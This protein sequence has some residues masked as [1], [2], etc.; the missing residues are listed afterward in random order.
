MWAHMDV[1][2]MVPQGWKGEFDGWRP[3]DAWSNAIARAQQAEALGFESIWVFDH[4]T[5]VPDPTQEITFESF[6]M[7]AAL[8]QAT[9][10]ARIG[11]MVI[12]TGFRNPA[13]TAKMASTIDAIS[14]GRFEL[15]IGA[16]WK[17]DEWLAYGYGFP[18][19]RDRLGALGDH[20]EVI[21]RMLGPGNATFEGAYARVEGAINVPKGIQAHI[22]IVVGG[23]GQRVTFR[24]AARYADELNLVFLVPD[25]IREALPHDRQRL[26]DLVGHQEDQVQLVCIASRVA[27]GHPLAVAAHHDRDVGLDPLRH[28]DR[29]LDPRVGTLERGVPGAQHP[30]DHLQVVAQ[31]AE[32][33]AKRREAIAVRQPLIFLPASP[34]PKLEAAAGDHVDRGGHLRR[35]GRVAKAGADHHVADPRPRRRLRQRGE[36]GE[37]LEGDL[38]GWIRHGREVIE[39]PDRFEAQCLRLLRP[40]DRVGPG[41][42]GT[43]AVELA[44]P[45]LGNHHP[46]I[47]VC[48]HP[49]AATA[50]VAI[51][52]AR[53]GRSLLKDVG[54]HGCR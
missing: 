20:L 36:H 21:R 52:P 25:E 11:H 46:D 5:T 1:G 8:A 23:N 45:A 14:G 16:G 51:R 9:S 37:R 19:L 38:L 47:H 12:C 27:E 35:E 50:R 49:S 41:V 17:E 3:A 33:I 53:P 39:D 4:F 2:V 18:T 54:T 43:P 6:T 7:L 31:R 42:G 10:R 26:A 40:R 30:P 24:Y 32:A 13:L 22:P 34:D 29:A 15:G 28:V 44:L 48:P